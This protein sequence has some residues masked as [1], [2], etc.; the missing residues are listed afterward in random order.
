MVIIG[1]ILEGKSWF[2]W[3]EDRDTTTDVPKG[4]SEES[5]SDEDETPKAETTDTEDEVD[6]D[7]EDEEIEALLAQI[8]GDENEDEANEWRL[9]L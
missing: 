7:L 6:A 1:D 5:S 4:N 2:L 3:N 9:G 8:F